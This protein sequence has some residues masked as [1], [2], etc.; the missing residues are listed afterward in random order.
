VFAAIEGRNPDD[1]YALRQVIAK[2]D[3][4]YHAVMTEPEFTTAVP[5][6]INAGLIGCDL[7]ADRYWHTAAGHDLYTRRMKRRGLFGWIH[8]IPPALDC[9]GPPQNGQWVLAPGVFERAVR[10]WQDRASEIPGT[11]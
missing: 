2:G 11:A 5:R 7:V 3:G 6:L 1:G 10:Q 4:I 9:L 8:A